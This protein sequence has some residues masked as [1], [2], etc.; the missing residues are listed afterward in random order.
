[1]LIAYL[2]R[3]RPERNERRFYAVYWQETLLGPAVVR[4]HG[5]K[6]VWA[7]VLAPV[8]FP[9]LD[10]AQ[11]YIERLIRRRVRRGYRL[12]EHLDPAG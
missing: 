12:T 6:G 8:F 7:R 4:V 3:I 10:A 9:D 1:M 11:P 2:E 5:R